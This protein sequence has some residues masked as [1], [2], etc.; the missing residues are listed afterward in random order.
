MS[1]GDDRRHERLRR[2][3][4]DRLSPES[5]AQASEE[6]TG[7][8]DPEVRRQAGM[9]AVRRMA[10]TESTRGDGEQSRRTAGEKTSDDRRGRKEG[11]GN[12]KRMGGHFD[13]DWAGRTILER[14]LVG[15]GDWNIWNEAQWTAYMESNKKLVEQVG[16]RV[17]ARAH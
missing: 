6:D 7:Q 16:G 10:G 11:G 14:Y 17:H 15:G 12:E 1:A 9:A 8:S 4:G 2:N 13:S 5:V 3:D